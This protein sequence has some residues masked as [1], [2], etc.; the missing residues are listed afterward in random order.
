ML[1]TIVAL[2]VP[3]C[4]YYI[5][6]VSSQ[7]AFFLNRCHRSLLSV[8][9]QVS[10]RIDGLRGM[11]AHPTRN[12]SNEE[13]RIAES[14]G[15]PGGETSD[16]C[17][18]CSFASYFEKPNPF[19]KLEFNLITTDERPVTPPAA[20]KIKPV[21][22][23]Q[24]AAA[25]P[26]AH[27][28]REPQL[29]LEFKNVR[30]VNKLVMSYDCGD[31]PQPKTGRFTVT[32]QLD[33]ILAGYIDRFVT[34]ET[35]AQ[36]DQKDPLAVQ[37][38]PD[39][40]L[41]DKIVIAESDTGTAVYEGGLS[42]VTI[43]NLWEFLDACGVAGKSTSAASLSGGDT[44]AP[45][46]DNKAEK[47]SIKSAQARASTRL[48]DITAGGV[49]YK[50]FLRPVQ[51]TVSKTGSDSRRGF[52]LSIAGL[53]RSDQ[54]AE[55]SFA[56]S[57]TLLLLLLILLILTILSAPLIK[58]KLIG[59]KDRLRRFDALLTSSAIFLGTAILAVTLIDGYTY[60]SLER[61]LDEQLEQLAADVGSNLREE[62][63]RA[64]KQL[65]QLN[66]NL[67]QNLSTVIA[68]QQETQAPCPA[69]GTAEG[70][71]H[72]EN[73]LG[74]SGIVDLSTAEYPYFNSATW[75]DMSGEQKIKFTTRGQH[76]DFI[77]IETR[78]FFR[79]ARDGTLWNL[80]APGNEPLALA[81][82]GLTSRVSG[83]NVAVVAKPTPEGDY[84][85]SLDTRL[86]SLY[87]PVL[88]TGYGFCVLDNSG[89]VRFHSFDVKNLEENFFEESNNDSRLRSAVQTRTSDFMDLQYLGR[90]NRAFVAPIEGL[91]WTLV[92]F[93]DKGVL[94]TVNLE[95][96]TLSTMLGLGYFIFL[97]LALALV[98][99]FSPR[100]RLARIWPSEASAGCYRQ[101]LA[102][103]LVLFFISLAVITVSTR[104]WL[105]VWALLFPALAIAHALSLFGRG[106][107]LKMQG[108]DKWRPLADWRRLYALGLLATLG[109]ACV[110]PTIAFFRLVRNEQVR[111]FITH[112]QMS[113][114]RGLERRDERVRG[115]YSTQ[116]P[117]VYI[118]AANERFVNKRLGEHCDIYDSFFFGTRHSIGGPPSGTQ[119]S[120][121]L[122]WFFRNLSPYYNE[123][124]ISSLKLVGGRASDDRWASSQGA[125]LALGLKPMTGR[126]DFGDG[127]NPGDTAGEATASD[128]PDQ[129]AGRQPAETRHSPP[130][131]Q[132]WLLESR[133]P[134]FVN[135]R[136]PLFWLM[137]ICAGLMTA[138][139]YAVVR[140][141]ANR[142]VL[143]DVP[144]PHPAAAFPPVFPIEQNYLFISA[145]A[146]NGT[147]RFDPDN[148]I[149]LDAGRIGG[150]TW[151]EE[152]DKLDNAPF[153][154]PV[155]LDNFETRRNDSAYNLKK[156]EIL[157]RVLAK[158]RRVVIVSTVHPADLPLSEDSRKAGGDPDAPGKSAKKGSEN[159]AAAEGARFK[160]DADIDR[161]SSALS[162]FVIVNTYE[163]ADEELNYNEGLL[164]D[165][166]ASEP[167]GRYLNYIGPRVTGQGVERNDLLARVGD[168]AETYYRSIWSLCTPGERLTL[169][170]V[171]RDGFVSRFDPDLRP[172]MQRGLVVRDPSLRLMDECFRR[173]VIKA[174]S[175]EGVAAYRTDTHSNWEKWKAPLLLILLAVIGFLF[176]TQKDLFDSTISTVS[177]VTGGLLALLRLFGMFQ[178]GKDQPGAV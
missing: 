14:S 153:D 63:S 160:K 28:A 92:T 17:S 100:G 134:P 135:P 167:A 36:D 86:L 51:L 140:F 76:T 6:Y 170:S 82:E 144:A 102:V 177:A 30:A 123:T 127:L 91:P 122:D 108:L 168:Q 80:K 78:P 11:V 81:F 172:L 75:A 169:M 73:I 84:V 150:R 44:G 119:L 24:P 107:W 116:N 164:R 9:K 93:R 16:P 27:A 70:K 64:S 58:L 94:R 151:L 2:L 106:P 26:V 8:A 52:D 54:L 68:S 19:G 65:D 88:P 95:I 4:F 5:F 55:K 178:K 176:L 175:D 133:Q 71:Y 87:N 104:G 113:L 145:P 89:L 99:L 57:Y 50:L 121:P 3:F 62:L 46:G 115:N 173:F 72:L 142:L 138:A 43:S 59:A 154:H 7:R 53:V 141:A 157:N 156:L 98:V 105:I 109:V 85:S 47:T 40:E 34:P 13:Q 114:A 111:V 146:F 77:N 163:K 21:A 90:S 143:L 22:L 41:F 174:A 37:R 18:R 159:G 120:G 29:S 39:E 97:V 15:N 23:A 10:S 25:A 60:A 147:A 139:C 166:N 118:G 103:N 69:S 56:F 74:D 33:T 161:W 132:A 96:A 117:R 137:L 158:N 128:D 125:T 61:Q 42:A 136:E 152:R 131:G 155:V 129:Q 49:E 48:F 12:C 124:C 110:A 149:Y 38:V 162:S 67:E 148:V 112:G 32:T 45:A 66:A 171:G 31:C 79:Q 101:I 35:R 20:S 1:I 126:N 83:E 130:A 165:L